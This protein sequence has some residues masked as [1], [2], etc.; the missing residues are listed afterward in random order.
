MAGGGLTN[1]EIAQTLFL[2]TNIG[3]ECGGCP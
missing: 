1:R 2:T 3:D